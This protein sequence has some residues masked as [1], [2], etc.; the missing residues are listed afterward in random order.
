MSKAV[1]ELTDESFETEVGNG[2]GLVLV[3]F[4]APW[5]APCRIVAP[6]IE[7]LAE[8]YAGR[9]RFAKLNVDEAPETASQFG[10]A[11]IPTLAI[12]RDGEPVSGVAGAVPEKY[13][14]DLI[15]QQLAA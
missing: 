6:I 12:F 14:A 15:D 11:S 10:I 5:C 3:D 2:T 7:R 8:Q 9:V 13:L 4:W 1:M